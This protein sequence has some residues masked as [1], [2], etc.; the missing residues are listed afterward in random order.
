MAVGQE[1]SAT[2]QCNAPNNHSSN[3]RRSPSG[4]QTRR[5]NG[6]AR[7]LFRHGCRSFCHCPGSRR[8]RRGECRRFR[9]HNLQRN[10]GN[11]WSRRSRP[12]R[13]THRRS[14]RSA[15]LFLRGNLRAARRA[16]Q[17]RGGFLRYARR[18]ARGTFHGRACPRSSR[19]RLCPDWNKRRPA[20]PAENFWSRLL[21]SAGRTD[22]S[23]HGRGIRFNSLVPWGRRYLD[24][25]SGFLRFQDLRLSP[26][27]RQLLPGNN[28]PA[29]SETKP[30]PP[31]EFRRGG[32]CSAT[33]GTRRCP[34]I[35]SNR[36]AY[37]T[38]AP[39]AK[40][41]PGTQ[42]PTA[43]RAHPACVWLQI[44]G[45]L[46]L[47]W[48]PTLSYAASGS[49]TGRGPFSGATIR[50]LRRMS[51]RFRQPQSCAMSIEGLKR[52]WERSHS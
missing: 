34:L 39:A 12:R 1:S 14:A 40:F 27:L 33:R 20:G 11:C 36:F 18:S 32:T 4:K 8:C 17:D 16:A 10:E 7:R 50:P 2:K 13:R 5:G 3:A 46:T 43:R 21:G 26:R 47:P 45:H 38:S 25:Q 28:R 31:A 9:R 23:R 44:S 19:G 24:S 48:H 30:T 52:Q 6:T 22:P 49:P 41:R 15:K 35:H 37:R 29:R 42:R 51:S